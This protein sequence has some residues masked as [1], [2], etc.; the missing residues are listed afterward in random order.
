MTDKLTVV[1]S[2]FGSARIKKRIL[3]L[4]KESN[5]IVLYYFQRNNEVLGLRDDVL[6][7]V[8]EYHCV[9]KIEDGKV[10]SRI[11]Y[12][13]LLI[14]KLFSPFKKDQNFYIFG[15][16]LTFLI[17]F[18]H[19]R[20]TFE[21]ADL[22][23]VDV[24]PPMK[25]VLQILDKIA[26]N[27]ISKLVLTSEYHYKQYYARFISPEK[28]LILRNKLPSVKILTDL[29]IPSVEINEKITI[30]LLGVLRYERVIDL[31]ISF[32][33]NNEAN[34]NL[35]IYGKPS[36]RYDNDYLSYLD[37]HNSNISW[38]GMYNN[39][40]DLEK[41]YSNIDINF[42]V[43]DNVYNNVRIA[44]PNKLYESI[45]FKRPILCCT[46]SE[47]GNEVIK[48][49]IGKSVRTDS[50]SVFSEDILSFSTNQIEISSQKMGDIDKSYYFD[51]DH[52]LLS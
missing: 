22:R 20:I 38:N 29:N 9:G 32:I 49:G 47:F 48:L 3:E 44:I 26:V 5:T 52:K 27:K 33:K 16:D 18:L 30:G 42:V 43:Y 17:L 39:P 25:N 7:L 34:Y 8:D 12:Y 45:L 41:I 14:T 28:V 24:K 1:T 21:V 23:V 50:Y 35:I 6:D 2:S 36:G 19:G 40:E 10:F 11:W 13:L 37:A 31:L 46:E 4:K 15:S 51:M